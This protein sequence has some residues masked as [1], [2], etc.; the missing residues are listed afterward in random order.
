MNDLCW[1]EAVNVDGDGENDSDRN[2]DKVVTDEGHDGVITELAHENA[3]D[4]R[5][6]ISNDYR[7]K[8]KFRES[9][10]E[11]FDDNGVNAESVKQNDADKGIVLSERKLV[12]ETYGAAVSI[13]IIVAIGIVVIARHFHHSF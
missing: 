9:L 5:Y 12:V 1:L 6:E 11:T 2:N 7:H 3:D 13:A 10:S 8:R 4:A